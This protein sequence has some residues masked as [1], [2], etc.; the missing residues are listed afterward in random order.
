MTAQ[1][2]TRTPLSRERVLAA[3][4]AL[5]DEQGIEALTM[6]NLAGA[7]GVEA[8]SLYYHV[9]NKEALL[10]G[11]VDTLVS[12]IENELGGLGVPDGEWKESLRN[13]ILTARGVML[14]HPWAP[15]VIETRTTMTP[16]LLRYMDTLL[17]ILVEGGFSNDLG[18]HAMHALGSR[19]L[20][21]NQELFAPSDPSD[22]DD[23]M[24]MLSDVAP[25][26][27]YIMGMLSEV[28]HDDPD[29]TLGW[30][31]DQTEFEFGLDLLLD[32]LEQRMLRT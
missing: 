15:S 21:F 25:S 14:Q 32:G 12:E 7:L 16:T 4:I 1:P 11:V 5:A 28:A 10:D 18:H 30:C 8:M 23:G 2:E 26:L 13:R 24:A 9:A 29:S 27:P 17:G 19:A 31:D 3:A 6:R 20:G 22:N